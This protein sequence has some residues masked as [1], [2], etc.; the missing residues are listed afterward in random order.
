MYPKTL[1]EWWYKAHRWKKLQNCLLFFTFFCCYCTP[2]LIDEIILSRSNE[3]IRVV[4]DLYQCNLLWNFTLKNCICKPISILMYR[5]DVASCIYLG[6]NF[7]YALE[8]IMGKFVKYSVTFTA[9]TCSIHG[10]L[11]SVVWLN[12]TYCCCLISFHL[13]FH[14]PVRK[15]CKYK[16]M[17][18]IICKTKEYI[19]RKTVSDRGRNKMINRYAEGGGGGGEQN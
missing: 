14:I 2:R 17:Y 11:L 19:A 10:D 6:I 1:I 12:K 15:T 4:I 9:T 18:I 5:V 3:A 16:R 7:Q 13:F 8:S